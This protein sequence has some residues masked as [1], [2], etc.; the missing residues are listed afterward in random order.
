MS[1]NVASLNSWADVEGQLT[2]KALTSNRLTAIPGLHIIP[3]VQGSIEVPFVTSSPVFRTPA[4]NWTSS[5]STTLGQRTM[6]VCG[7]QME[8]DLCDIELKTK[9]MAKFMTGNPDLP[10]EEVLAAEKLKQISKF[11]ENLA[12]NGNSVAGAGSLSLCNGLVYKLDNTYSAS[13]SNVTLT[14]MT[15]SNA[16]TIID[17]V[18]NALDSAAKEQD[19]VV[20]LVGVAEFDKIRQNLRNN[21]WYHH[22]SDTNQPYVMQYPGFSNVTVYGIAS[23]PS[24]RVIATFPENIIYA[25]NVEP[26]S[27][28]DMYYSKDN[29]SYRAFAEWYQSWDVHFEGLVARM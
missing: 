1:F 24:N 13:T 11:A 7:V 2:I 20:V 21:N 5:G 29:R 8:E 16:I 14:A 27:A 17:A 3:N 6:T 19:N 15:S 4:C 9:I 18:V 23:M 22:S 12:V 25:F 10:F 26:N 28:L